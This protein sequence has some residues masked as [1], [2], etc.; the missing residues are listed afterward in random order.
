MQF[1]LFGYSSCIL[2]LNEFWQLT[3]VESSITKSL[4]ITKQEEMSKIF[5]IQTFCCFPGL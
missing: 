3:A 4:S 1:G 5:K 2:T